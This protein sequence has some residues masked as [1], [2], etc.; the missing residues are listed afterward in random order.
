MKD[1]KLEIGIVGAGSRGIVCFAMGI[2]SR[3]D[4]FV[5]ALCDVNRKRME[6]QAAKLSPSPALYSDIHE[7]LKISRPDA[8]VVAGP[9]Y[10]HKEHVMAALDAS[11]KV[12]VDK[13]LATNS[14]DCWEIIAA[15]RKK[16]VLA[17]IG[18][19]MR[20]DPTLLRLKSI[21]DSGTLGK[22]LM[23][24]NREYYSGGRSY[25]ARW[26]RKYE[27]SG[28][29]WIHKGS[30]DFDVFN[31]LMGFPKPSKVCAFAGTDVFLPQNI[32]FE[33]ENGVS[34][35]PGCSTCHY[36]KKCPDAM[37]Y[38]GEEWQGEARQEDG[39]VKDLCIYMSDKD[40]HDNGFAMVEYEG[41]A[42]AV[43]MECFSCSLHDRKYSVIGDKAVAELSLKERKI[44]VSP[45]WDSTPTVHEI[46]EVE[47]GHGGA[48]P[49][50]IDSF[51]TAV[52]GGKTPLSTLEEGLLSTAIG[53][54]AEISWRQSRCVMISELVDDNKWKSILPPS[55]SES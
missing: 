50:L 25:M 17:M 28:G 18:F 9:D 11:V 52:K 34:P 35:G 29:L 8:I 36:L 15:A 21:I 54:A 40:V 51:I 32:P 26:N 2:A 24:E 38:A 45:R 44:I 55:S 27:L 33:L 16:G 3:D 37:P 49:S 23:I 43:H 14:K 30:H 53:E 4:A 1:G 6:I 5:S 42:R 48:D 13:P 22:I 46:P 31:W 7:M 19:N 10:T 47:G 41:G 39:Y 12:L 20:H